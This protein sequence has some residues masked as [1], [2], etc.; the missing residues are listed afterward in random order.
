MTEQELKD[1]AAGLKRWHCISTETGQKLLDEVYRL[2]HHIAMENMH[3]DIVYKERD[4]ALRAVEEL[5]SHN[6]KEVDHA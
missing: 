6:T 2:R 1:I 4:D 3:L 5:N